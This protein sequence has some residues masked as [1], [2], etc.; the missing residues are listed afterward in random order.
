MADA[1]EAYK[2]KYNNLTSYL[3]DKCGYADILAGQFVTFIDMCE[4]PH[5]ENTKEVLVDA[6]VLDKIA[7]AYWRGDSERPMMSRIYGI[8]FESK[9]ELK[10]YQTM[11][12]EAKKRDHRIL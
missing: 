1:H 10:A 5:V 9:D 11:M 8:S 6:F 3:S 12:E 2:T 4:G 7:G